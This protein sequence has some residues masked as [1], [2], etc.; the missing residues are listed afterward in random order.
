MGKKERLLRELKNYSTIGKKI[1]FKDKSRKRYS[2]V[3]EVEEEV[4]VWDKKYGYKHFIQ[5][6]K[7]SEEMKRKMKIYKNAKYGFRFCYYTLD[8]KFSRIVWG[9]FASQ[10]PEAMFRE[11]IIKAKHKFLDK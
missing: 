5:K 2:I 10:M 4:A 6:I 11:L 7:Y 8:A 9:Q 1:Y 3:G